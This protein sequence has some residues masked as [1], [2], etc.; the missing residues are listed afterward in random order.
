MCEGLDCGEV[1]C[2]AHGESSDC[3]PYV[4][5]RTRGSQVR[6]AEESAGAIAADALEPGDIDYINLH[7]TGNPHQRS[8]GQSAVTSVCGPTKPC[9]SP[10]CQGTYLGAAGAPEA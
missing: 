8:L 1:C 7:G 9:R 2:S 10:W 6:D 4:R 5:R 3:L